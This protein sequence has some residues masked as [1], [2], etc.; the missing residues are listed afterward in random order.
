M[1]T[2]VVSAYNVA[3][4]PEFGGHFWVY[5]QYAHAL[6]RLGCEV[7]WLERLSRDD[8]RRDAPATIATFFRRME[9]YGFGGKAILYETAESDGEAPLRFIGVSSATAES[10]FRRADLLLNFHY[11]IDP[12]LLARFRRTALVDIDPGLLQFWISHG[13]LRVPAHNLYLTIG[14]TVG[15]PGA[16][17]SDCGLPWIHIRPPVCLDLWPYIHDRV[18]P[19]FTTV[20]SWLSKDCVTVGRGEAMKVLYE[21]NKRVSFMQFAELP[22]RTSCKLEVAL[23][24]EGRLDAAD[25]E[26]LERN[27]WRVRHSL[28]VARTPDKYQT[29]IQASRGEFS[30]VKPSCI[31]FQNAWV[32]DRT[33]CYLAS[34]KP[35]VVQHTGPSSFLP[36]GEGMFRF[37]TVEEAAEALATIDT[38]YERHCRA[39]REI[40]EAFFDARLVLSDVLDLVGRA[41][42]QTHEA[43]DRPA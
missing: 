32:S 39:A 22:E 26:L 5:F 29:Y 3:N 34:G 4:T 25:R 30:C 36:S 23:Y 1:A 17:F 27:G 31:E 28:E 11:A 6:R 42:R 33:L 43:V 19:R 18:C 7:F 20:S 21:N 41:H 24:L 16:R 2:V 12:A 14:E 13:Q 15:T 40:A 35:A 38:D 10:V 9:R 37:S 8:P